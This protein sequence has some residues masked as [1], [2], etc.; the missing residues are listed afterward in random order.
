MRKS[1]LF[2]RCAALVVILSGVVGGSLR[3][4]CPVGDLNN[5]CRVDFDDVRRLADRW[6]DAGCAAPD[7]EADIDG[8]P[9]VDGRDYAKLADNWLVTGTLTLAINEFMAR[10]TQTIRDPDDPDGSFDDW[11]EIHNYGSEA[12]DIG[13]FYLSDDADDPAGARIPTNAP[14]ATTIAAGGYLLVWAD[15]EPGQGPLHVNF[16]LSAGGEDVALFDRNHRLIDS[17]SFG[18]QNPDESYGRLPNGSGSWRVF[19]SATPGS[20]NLGDPVRVVI[21]EIMFHPGHVAPEPENIGLEYI[22]LHNAGASA[23]DVSGWRLTDGVE[24]A[25][26][27]RAPLD[28][29]QYLVLA[30]DVNEFK[31]R[32]PTVINVVGGWLGHLSN[33]GERIEVCDGSGVVIDRVRY[34]D[35]GDWAMRELGPVDHEHRGWQWSDAA[36][37]GGRSLELVNP[38]FSNDYGQNW[39]ASAVQNG[40]P[41]AANS[42][43]AA[44]IAPIISDALHSPTIPG[45]ADPVIVAARILDETPTGLTVTL[46]YRRD[47]DPTFTSVTMLDNGLSGDG[48]AGDGVYAGTIPAQSDTTLVEFYIRA[49]D[50]QAAVRTWPAPTIVD[51]APQQAAN[52]L[53]RVDGSFSWSW[54][55]GDDPVYVIIMKAADLA[56]LDDI[57]DTD[58]SGPLF[59]SEAMSNAQMNATFISVYGYDTDVHYRCGVR[60]RGNRSRADPP[61]SYRVNFP[62]DRDWNGV[63]AINLNSK[64]THLQRM[65]S[66]MFR[67]AGLA[68]SDSTNV[69]LYVNGRDPAAAQFNE[70]YGR[71][72]AN[73]AYDSDWADNHFPDD[74]DG[75]LYRATYVDDGYSGRTNADLDYKGTAANPNLPQYR[76]HY[77]KQTNTAQDDYTDLLALI[78]RLNNPATSDADFLREVSKSVNIRQWMRYIATDVL[79]GNRE[80]GLYEGEGDDY[81]LYCGV[82][83]PRFQLI[84]HDLDTV[85]G[86]GDHSYDPARTI[87][88][89]ATVDGLQ[90]LLAQ[91]D[92]IKMYY[93][94]L[95]ELALTTFNPGSFNPLVDHLLADWVPSTEINGAG[96]IKQF[97]VERRDAVVLGAATQVPRTFQVVSALP[98]ID[99][100]P[101]TTAGTAALT[102][103]FDAVTTRS[104][105]VGGVV[106]PDAGW[107]QRTGSWSLGGIALN[108]GV[109]R[110]IVE[111]FDAANGTGNIVQAGYIDI[112]RE[113]GSTNDYPKETA[114]SAGLTD[115]TVASIRLLTRDSYLPGVGVL[116]RVE[117]LDGAG[118]IQRE[119]WDSTATLTVDSPSV[120]L[121]AGEVTLFNG[122]GTA[123]VTFSGSGDFTLTASVGVL[124]ADRTLIDLSAAPVTMVS[125]GLAASQTWSGVYRITGGDFSIPAGVTLTLNPGALVL[126]D[127]VA[128]GTNGPD[129]DVAGSIQSLGTAAS[130]VTITAAAAGLNWGEIHCVN[131]ADC[132]FVYTDIS[133]AGRSPGVGHSG[134]GPTFR[135]SGTKLHFDHCNLTDNAGK[136]MDV[137]SGSDLAFMN[138]VFARCVMG[139]EIAGTALLF[140]D[141]WITEMH[142]ADDA[143]GI[144]VHDQQPGQECTMRRATIADLDDD[145]VDTLGCDILLRDCVIRDCKDK[146]ISIYAGTTTIDHCLIVENNKAPEDPTVS[147]IA[148]KTFDGGTAVVNIDRSTV[149]ST[150]TAGVTDMALQSHNKYG[151]AAG[152]I[153][154]NVTNSIIDATDPIDAQAPYSLADFHIRYSDIHSEAMPG[155]G[156][157]TTDPAFENPAAHDYHLASTSPCIDAGDPAADPDPDLTVADMGYF[158][159]DQGPINVPGGSL[160]ADTVWTAPEGPYRITGELTVPFGITLTITPGTSV[161]FE[162]NTRIVVRGRLIAEGEPYNLIR[163]TRTPGSTGVWSGL[164]FIDTVRD[165]RIR[166]AVLEF[167]QTDNGM[168]GVEDSRLLVENCTLARTTLRRIR[169]LDSWLVV[170]GCTFT[171]TMEAGGAPTNNRTEH[172]W[173]AGILPGGEF[174]I[175]GNVFGRTPGHND[176]IDVDGPF[177]PNPIPQIRNNVFLG[178][179]DDALDLETD[180]HIEGNIFMH[181]REDA[182]NTDP[183][184][185]NVISAGSGHA[186]TVVR[187][188]FYDVEHVSLVKEGAFMTFVNNTVAGCTKSALYFDLA[189]QTSGP[190]RGA[191]VDGCIFHNCAKEFDVVAPATELAVHNS[192]VSAAWHGY[193]AGNIQAD[194]LFVDPNGDFRLRADSVASE[195]G[196]CGLDMG[197]YVPAG[198]VVCGEP[199]ATTW[200]T[201]ALLTVGG[202]GITHYRYS[203][204]NPAGPY[205]PDTA[206]DTLISLAGLSDGVSYTVYVMGKDS[207]GIWQ[208][209]PT[210]S[211]TWTVDTTARRLVINEVLGHTHGNDP[212]IIELYYDGP[213]PLNLTGYSLTDDPANPRKF[214]FSASTVHPV[215]M[216]PGTYMVLYGDLN[217]HLP[218][219]IGFA[220]TAEGEGLYLY[221]SDGD[222]VDSVEFGMQINEFTIGRTGRDHLW[223]LCVPT[224][225]GANIRAALGDCRLLRINEWLADAHR[226]FAEDFVEL[227]NPTSWPVR[228]GGLY[229]TDHIARPTRHR[230]A[231]LSFIAP[232][233]Y[234]VF[235]ADDSN[236]PGSLN[237]Q[238]DPYG[239]I[240]TLLDSEQN[241]IDKVIFK[242]QTTDVSQGRAPD[243][244]D[245]F[246]YFDLPT[247]GV[248]N[249]VSTPQTVT[250]V[251]ESA[252]KRVLVPTA[253]IGTTWRSGMLFDDS[254]WQACIGSPGGVGYERSTGYES[255][256]TCDVSAMYGVMESCYIRIPFNVPGDPAAITR[257]TLR[258]RYDDGF[259]AWINGNRVGSRNFAAA[260]IAWNDDADAG[261]SDSAAVVFEDI[262]ISAYIGSLRS[263]GNLLAVQGLN[264]GA[265]SSD[266]LISC[267]LVA[268]ITTSQDGMIA[269][270]F[271][272]IDGLRV[273]ELMYHPPAGSECDYIELQNIGAEPLDLTGVR[274]L[275]GVTFEFPFI[276]LDPGEYVTVAADRAAF[277]AAYGAS[278]HV[279]GPYAGNLSNGGEN[280]L[281]ALP[282]PLEAAIQ[283]FQYNDAWYPSTDGGGRSLHIRNPAADPMLWSVP[284]S[285]IDG[286]PTPNA[287]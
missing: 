98:V 118:Q 261:H 164:Q 15:N 270:A 13:G 116:V 175:E 109:N 225:G 64:Y 244:A 171:D 235:I 183:G 258:V 90:R 104:M 284:G 5:D 34:A 27:S 19:T 276:E 174:L 133:R 87:W 1:L 185:S 82:N 74:P 121:S 86:R 108:P 17:V 103:R 2:P 263:G 201:S 160:A 63:N 192:I 180:A 142:A 186:F 281:L 196:P 115:A 85:L 119:V 60:N 260:T 145:G 10:N 143:D 166:H 163:L 7:C 136:L 71:Y 199:D 230:I 207:A 80:G 189:G 95:Y 151:V 282:W 41:G 204:N 44:N 128:S 66:V 220:L 242:P 254:G 211:R 48:P 26:P 233:G 209:E 18:P 130:P 107:N 236:R 137:A 217:T 92:V 153:T 272:L 138:T 39:T 110:I 62:N 124:Q 93:E 76:L 40:T 190:G 187:N 67:M 106:V 287:P 24:Y 277:T 155:V 219:H 206:V 239:E 198:A 113:V 197:A 55:P 78:D 25:I 200:R 11:I 97:V 30:A 32:Y 89:Y 135:V 105:A 161:Y 165:N 214:V 210:A 81:A 252:G 100:Y 31:A 173:G 267:E 29:G 172:I 223:R 149:V 148:A 212:D 179:G 283:R 255:Y 126:I 253:D 237:F 168:I 259:V 243:G 129:I 178:G 43:M 6:L 141:G 14:Q 273:T 23:V 9:G 169:T 21:N 8:L 221:G 77:P 147:S 99:G 274:L 111:A 191:Y 144:Y 257:L 256:I 54:T 266:F 286:P 222:L 232:N 231:D 182:Y 65:G 265:T 246:A 250:L 75:N 238:L 159:H 83:D 131:A 94:Q 264:D 36:D 73:E 84:P 279:V 156:N 37:G 79:V 47:G 229:L 88:G 218:N 240:L 56:E 215:S 188:V 167:G 35:E 162:P 184:E 96:R 91:P 194:P 120:S 249:P 58:Y 22:E 205:S 152:A 140:E 208:T 20:A 139:P 247:P 176:A 61:M 57:G 251:P 127:G 12:I 241:E 46:Y 53:Y 146:G 28:A 114:P 45:P 271:A 101:T 38:G 70:T 203:L 154:W 228:L 150:R 69:R 134:T 158:Y 262:D 195:S 226:L 50:A 16:A 125:G 122:L 275:D 102:G 234:A 177:R 112:L 72:A 51:G 268:Q 224:L 157:I 285:W 248:A 202:P 227:H 269:R 170:R 49:A 193:G 4:D 213:A 3:A 280:I 123:M 117:L 216:N 59:A 68:A 33:S 278:G 181:Y 52:A 42:T 132:N 245:T